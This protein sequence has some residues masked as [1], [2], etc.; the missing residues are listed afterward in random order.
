MPGPGRLPLAGRSAAVPGGFLR[1]MPA[2]LLIIAAAFVALLAISTGAVSAQ[3]SAPRPTVGGTVPDPDSQY[4]GGKVEVNEGT[5]VTIMVALDRSP[6]GT[7]TV[8]FKAFAMEGSAAGWVTV[9]TDSS[10]SGDQ[11]TLTFTAA[12]YGIAQPVTLTAVH[13]NIDNTPNRRSGNIWITSTGVNYFFGGLIIVRVHVIDIDVAGLT[14]SETALSASE[15]SGT[16]SFTVKLDTEPTDDVTVTITSDDTSV[17]RVNDN[18]LTFTSTNYGTAQTVTIT[19]V[20]DDIVND[21]PLRTSVITIAADGGGDGTDQNETLTFTAIDNDTRGVTI[22]PTAVTV[23]EA[24]GAGRTAEYTVRLNSQPTD[25]VTVDFGGL[26][27]TDFVVNPGILYFWGARDWNTDQIVTVTA[28]DDGIDEGDAETSVIT[29]TVS[30]GDYGSNNVMAPDVTVTITD[31]D[32][33]GI[34]I[35]PT[36]VTVTEAAGPNHSAQYSFVLDSEPESRVYVTL[37]G[38]NGADFLADFVVK[39]GILYFS[40]TDWDTAKIVTVTAIDDAIDEGDTDTKVI[41]HTVSGLGFNSV[42]APDVTVNITDDDTRG[43]TIVPT[44]VTVTEAAGRNHVA[45]YWVRLNSQPSSGFVTVT[46]G[47]HEGGDFVITP[48]TLFFTDRHWRSSQYVR[49]TATDDAIDEGDAETSVITHTVSGGDYGSNNVMAP[50]VTVVITD[51]DNPPGTVIT[52]DSATHRA[53]NVDE[54]T[55]TSVV[56]KT[57]EST[58]RGLLTWTLEGDDRADF[59]ITINGQGHGELRFANVPNYEMA[60]DSDT[61]NVYD[62][63]VKVT[64]S[65]GS[66][67]DALM[68]RVTVDDVNE[69]PTITGRYRPSVPENSTAVITLSATDEDAS[70][71]LTWS[72]ESSVGSVDDGSKFTIDPSSGA[73]SF[74]SAPDF[75]TPTDIGATAMNN[76]YV[77]VVKVTDAGGLSDTHPIL[78]TVTATNEAPEITTVSATHTAFNV[79]EN[80]AT[81]VVIKTY[82]AADVG[83]GSVLTWTLEGDD[84]ADFTITENAQGHGELKFARVPNY[85]MAADSDTDNVY[86]VTVKATDS[87]GSLPDTLMVRVT[88]DD[89]NE[90]PVITSPPATRSIPEN[91]TAVA[92]FSATDVDASDTLTWSVE[93]ADDGGKFTIDPSSGAL[94]FTSAPDFETPTD[95]GD[96]AMNNTY[97]VTVKVSDARGLSATHTITVT[98]T[99]IN[100]APQITT[101]CV[102]GGAVVDAT[103]EGL[104][105]DCGMLL[106]ARDT[107]AGTAALNWSADTPITEWN[108]VVLGET[109]GRVTELDLG[110]LGLNGR[111]PTELGGL[112][113][114]ME[115]SLSGNG[116]TGEIPPELGRLSNLNH[117]LLADN[118]LTGEIPPELGGLSNLMELSLSGNG[119]TGEIP[120]E[121][122]RLSNL[123]GIFFSP[124]TG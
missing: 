11:N 89:V 95:T 114:L 93:S 3:E 77:V 21:P 113:N 98:V 57:Y 12:N 14:L 117:L 73:L 102:S 44:T 72:V 115:L 75:E 39:P 101:D 107:L 47:G 18:E 85:E 41:T 10:M 22:M 118:G 50:D 84:S 19:A 31:D 38:Q 110:A 74:T 37:G 92:T 27:Q 96:T 111:I 53:F 7:V 86:D 108:G 67:P 79:D 105:S 122:G 81:S 123:N 70:D 120:P 68:V 83:G 65:D 20:D 24:A 56:I 100:E 76:T 104:V 90:A 80:T 34:T 97:V 66:L 116:L 121:L 32:T 36:T 61:D 78:V 69:A 13:D 1:R 112:S 88:V 60:A 49:V 23:T 109:S 99:T 17:A 52:T 58:T 8:T 106:A 4:K 62:V 54:N 48:D 45:Q 82:E 9:D 59:T 91:S 43:V 28:N 25:I 6:A 16:D 33:S 2:P 15:V 63:T 35:M 42:A 124:T 87:D 26:A 51:D 119:L 29:H 40:D 64:D 5:T 71:T 55:A 103:N 94:K 46:F 30:G